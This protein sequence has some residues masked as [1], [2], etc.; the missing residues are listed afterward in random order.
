MIGELRRPGSGAEPATKP[1][2]TCVQDLDAVI[3]DMDPTTRSVR[4]TT[5]Y[6]FGDEDALFFGKVSKPK[7]EITVKDYTD[8]LEPVPDDIVFPIVPNE[9][10]LR[11]ALNDREAYIKQPNMTVYDLYNDDDFLARVLQS[12]VS[13]METIARHPHPNFVR[14]HGVRVRRGRITGIVLDKYE[15]TLHSYIKNGQKLNNEKFLEALDSAIAHLHSLGLAHNDINPENIMVGP[16]DMPILIDFGSCGTFGKRLMSQGTE[17]WMD[18]VDFRSA[19]EHDI[20]AL[21]KLREWFVE[22]WF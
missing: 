4:Y 11:I 10:E 21:A 12:E 22:P 6:V 17:G 1:E 3:E 2:V 16:D 18:V 14:Y 9:P 20:Y 7:A 19:K 15:Y 5:F 13:I 8:A